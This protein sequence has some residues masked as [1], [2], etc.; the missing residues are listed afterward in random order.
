MLSLRTGDHAP[1]QFV[2]DLGLLGARPGGVAF[3]VSGAAPW[4]SQGLA[5]CG[6]AVLQQARNAFAGAF[7]ATDA[8]QH[9]SA[10]RRA[11][12]ACT[13]G[14]DRPTMAIAPTLVAAGDYIAGAYPATLEGA[15]RSGIAAAQAFT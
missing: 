14:L 9:L 10:E 8:I 5:T 4:L 11:T 12:F 7:M 13:P 2:F 15:V 6:Q 3:V 1:A